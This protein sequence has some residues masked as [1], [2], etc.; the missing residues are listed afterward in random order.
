MPDSTPNGEKASAYVRQ[1]DPSEFPAIADVLT[2]AFARDPLFNWLG[3]V[4]TLVPEDNKGSEDENEEVRR[5]LANLRDFEVNAMKLETADGLFQ[6]VVEKEGK[7]EEEE[8]ERIVACAIWARPAEQ[9]ESY[10]SSLVRLGWIVKSWGLR[11]IKVGIKIK[12]IRVGWLRGC[13]CGIIF[14]R[15]TGSQ[16]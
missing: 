13:C 15:S 4:R 5:T 2:R 10:L 9:K 8:K 7:G 12:Y 14:P 11:G 16:C 6:V 1:A 3:D